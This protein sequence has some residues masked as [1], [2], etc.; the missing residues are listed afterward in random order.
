MNK[1]CKE[2]S[3]NYDFF[4]GKKNRG[5]SVK[6]NDLGT[7]QRLF[8]YVVQTGMIV[9][10]ASNLVADEE[11]SVRV[12]TSSTDM[13]KDIPLLVEHSIA[14]NRTVDLYIALANAGEKEL[15]DLLS[16]SR[17]IEHSSVKNETLFAI[18]G[19]LTVIDPQKAMDVAVE[20]PVTERDPFVKAIIT[21][22][23]VTDL[24][25]VVDATASLDR[26]LR[27]TVLETI[28]SV[29]DD[30]PSQELQAIASELGH[31]EYVAHLESSSTAIELAND[32]STAWRVLV[33]DG[34]DDEL[35]LQDMILVAEAAIEQQGLD[36][37]F[38]L[39]EPFADVIDYNEEYFPRIK[40]FRLVTEA[41]VR[42]N[43]QDT[44]AYIENGSPQLLDEVSDHTNLQAQ[45]EISPRDRAFMTDT[46]QQLLLKSWAAM[47]P[48]TVLDRMEQIPFHL[49]PLACELA[50]AE[51]ARTEAER[52]IELIPALKHLG[53]AKSSTLRQIVANWAKNNPSEALDWV[54][55]TEHTEQ[56]SREDLIRISLYELVLEDPERAMKIAAAE[57]DSARLEAFVLSELARSDLDAAFEML[58]KVSDPARRTS[59]H[60][61]ADRAIEQGEV[62]RALE[63]FL[64]YEESSKEE[65]SWFS[66]FLDWCRANPVQLFERLDDFP[67][68]LR[69]EAAHALDY[70]S[71]PELT[72]EQLDYVGT[73]YKRPTYE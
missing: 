47:D 68:K 45:S 23:S 15:L 8:R 48:A 43:P 31:P 25:S 51:L 41:L 39:R 14:F 1:V 4:V 12:K 65:V 62:D 5:L 63:L 9:L 59:T 2:R 16:Y 52:A 29:R 33:E 20:L 55:T 18:A 46:V 35:Q 37:L 21:E 30:L 6:L 38:R 36:A 61:L 3:D 24:D 70:Y 67:P 58:P 19:R 69:Y 57:P 10:L 50:L 54:I 40:A 56:D 72:Q 53:A 22:W 73:I 32:V 26:D 27:L 60:W 66:F 42:N 28:A 64:E 13:K 34:L 44:W 49:Q 17:D 7:W 71:E 11:A